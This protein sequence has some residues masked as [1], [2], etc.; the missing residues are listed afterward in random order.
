MTRLKIS[1]S[2]I[3]ISQCTLVCHIISRT[4]M[5]YT[6]PNHLT[7]VYIHKSRHVKSKINVTPLSSQLMEIVKTINQDKKFLHSAHP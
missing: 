7:N 4:L 1:E 5:I 2:E 6:I 3:C